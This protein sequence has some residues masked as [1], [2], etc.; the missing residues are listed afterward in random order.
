MAGGVGDVGS[1]SG[2]LIAF[3]DELFRAVV[4]E[5]FSVFSFEENRV[6]FFVIFCPFW[7]CAAVIPCHMD[8]GEFSSFWEVVVYFLVVWAFVGAWVCFLSCGMNGIRSD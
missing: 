6:P 4:C 3:E 1:D 2:H 8:G 7:N 5:E